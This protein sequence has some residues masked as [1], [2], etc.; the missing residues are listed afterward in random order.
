MRAPHRKYTGA[1]KVPHGTSGTNSP[2]A[3]RSWKCRITGYRDRQRVA[4]G[5][6]E[7]RRFGCLRIDAKKG[8]EFSLCPCPSFSS[9]VRLGLNSKKSP[10]FLRGRGFK[11]D[12]VRPLQSPVSPGTLHL[13]RAVSFYRSKF[14]DWCGPLTTYRRASCLSAST[15][16]R[17]ITTYRS[18]DRR[19]G[20]NPG[21]IAGRIS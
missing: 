21:H 8:S 9:P 17:C 7:T 2:C 16:C 12:R 3:M 18:H 14:L 13:V 5:R 11:L 20:L 19:E 6:L 15:I 1:L 4:I 10:G